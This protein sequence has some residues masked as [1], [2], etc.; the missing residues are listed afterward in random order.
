MDTA[1]AWAER[2]LGESSTPQVAD[3]I[4]VVVPGPVASLV[5]SNFQEQGEALGAEIGRC[6]GCDPK[7]LVRKGARSGARL[8][9][10]RTFADAAAD[11][12]H[13][14][15]FDPIK[16]TSAWG[17]QI[18]FDLDIDPDGWL[19]TLGH[20]HPARGFANDHE[21]DIWFERLVDLIGKAALPHLVG[22]LDR[23]AHYLPAD[24]TGVMHAHSVV[25]GALI[26]DAAMASLRPARQIPMLSGVLA[27]FMRQLVALDPFGFEPRGPGVDH[28]ARIE[29]TM[30]RGSVDIEP[31]E[32]A[33]YPRFTYTPEGWKDGLPLMRTS[34]M[35]SEL[36]P[37][38]LFLRHRVAPGD[39]LIVEEPEAHLHPAMQVQVVRQLAALVNAGIRVLL[40]THSEWVLEELSN[41]V[42]AS[43]VPGATRKNV[44]GGD[45]ALPKDD[46]GVWAF[47]HK[48]RPRGTK[49]EEVRLAASGNLYSAC[50]DDVSAGT[51]EDWVRIAS[52]AEND[53]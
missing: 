48:K 37:I 6:F 35:V 29:E 1:L 41:V 33:S 53:G 47:R 10:R 39:L 20:I 26:E 18:A 2:L 30:L 9:F 43:T 3:A 15:A 40:T 27:D 22:G 12:E 49:I 36:A 14:L 38:V 23:P 19:Y 52:L 42:L 46:V 34:S 50:F 31:S 21:A 51:Y 25:V 44:G 16:L 4:R 5:R 45:V 7:A 24:R 8:V 13:T 17:E 11:F 32:V 28:A